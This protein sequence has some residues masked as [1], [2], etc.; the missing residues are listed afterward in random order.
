MGAG[1]PTVIYRMGDR[2][3]QHHSGANCG[4]SAR[5]LGKTNIGAV[6]FVCTDKTLEECLSGMVFGLPA[7]HFCYV[8][9]IEPGLPLFLFNYSDRKL[10]GIYEAASNGEMNINPHGWTKNG[11]DNTQYPAQV[12]VCIRKQCKFLSE[13]QYRKVL[14]KS[15]SDNKRFRFELDHMQ[16]GE[17]LSLF[18]SSPVARSCATFSNNPPMWNPSYGVVPNFNTTHEDDFLET[19][20]IEETSSEHLMV[21]SVLPNELPLSA[22]KWISHCEENSNSGAGSDGNGIK[23]LNSESTWEEGNLGCLNGSH[24]DPGTL[25]INPYREDDT[26]PSGVNP[27][28]EEETG[29]IST[30]PCRDEERQI[31]RAQSNNNSI[32]DEEERI[33]CK[34]K[35]LACDRENANVDELSVNTFAGTKS[36]N[37]PFEDEHSPAATLTSKEY[38]DV[39][40]KSLDIQCVIHQL[41]K[42]LEEVKAV[43]MDQHKKTSGLEKKL[44]DSSIL[45]QQ[46]RH[47]VVLLESRLQ[48]SSPESVEVFD[49]SCSDKP[50][51]ESFVE[52]LLGVDELI[53]VMGGYD[54]ISWLPTVDH[55]WPS[56]DVVKPLKPMNS[57]RSYASAAVLN[58]LIYNFGGWNGYSQRWY[59]TVERYDPLS[60]EWTSCPSLSE[61]K[62]CLAGASLNNKIYAVGG[63]NGT[64]CFR[65]VEMFDPALGRWIPSQSMIQKRFASA[66]AELDGVL[67]VVGGYDGKKYLKSAERFDPREASWSK[68]QSMNTSRGSHALTVLKGKLYALGGYDGNKY[69]PSIE[70]FDPCMGSWMAGDEM[71]CSRGYFTAPVIGE[72]IYAIGGQQEGNDIVD[73][74]ETYRLGHGWSVTE[75]KGIQKRCFFSAVLY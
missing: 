24:M 23:P 56:R 51:T 7:I 25:G 41:K 15:Y 52:P 10:H 44:A 39:A 28:W 35:Q 3:Q 42:E 66:A 65:E 36:N 69:I 40:M 32:E 43:S 61:M 68:V 64:N 46:L 45:L 31:C 67:Y 27:C 19:S 62:G 54:G 37:L 53:F 17:L 14:Y 2:I 18:D 9:N 72:T 60:N 70:I 34:L 55:Y 57:A 38:E 75:L 73:S 50:L 6:I 49:D 58:G 47:R 48:N 1:R 20:S 33:H 29:S 59:D 4:V 16:T 12:R 30:I 5:N 13:E 26:R 22:R 8:K 11:S 63:G 71:K 74:V 21:E